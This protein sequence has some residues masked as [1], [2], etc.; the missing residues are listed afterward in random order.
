MSAKKI[1]SESESIDS[2]I[3]AL[4]QEAA[5]LKGAW[6]IAKWIV[7]TVSGFLIVGLGAAL[8]VSSWALL[9][10][11]DHE[12]LLERIDV[13]HGKRLDRLDDQGDKILEKADKNG[14]KFDEQI[15]RIEDSL[16]P[17]GKIANMDATLNSL[18][19]R[20]TRV[21][22][23]V[24]P[25]GS[26]SGSIPGLTK[27]INGFQQT[28]VDLESAVNKTVSEKDFLKAIETFK[29]DIEIGRAHV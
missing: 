22:T 11:V 4:T 16:K 23:S 7:A 20:V 10:I 2:K 6:R 12:K 24:K 14:E 26:L 25:L 5:E 17:L 1:S 13:D 3:D 15:T 28:V 19:S 29:K 8:G 21:E 9:T 27:S 18:E